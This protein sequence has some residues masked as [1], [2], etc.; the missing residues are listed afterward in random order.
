MLPDAETHVFTCTGATQVMD[1]VVHDYNMDQHGDITLDKAFRVSCNNAFAQAALMMGDTA[2]RRTAEAFG[3]NDNFLFRD[4]VVENS[5][6]PTQ[7]RNS[8]EIAWSG[9]GQSQVVATPMHMCMVA[10]AIANDGVMMEPRLLSLVESPTGKVRLR[11]SQK[12][13]RT[14]C[15]PE[16]AQIIDGYMKDVVKSGTGT[17]AQVSGLTIAGKTGSAEG[18]DNGM[19]VTYPYAIS[20]LVENG[21]SGGSVAAPVA[22]QV[23]EYLRDNLPS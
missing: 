16:M 9:A 13:Y 19:D 5:V 17:R 18:S 12:V 6:Y 8:V 21:G 20:V 15:S 22:R 7:N 4:L 11:Y 1:H 2:L 23:F 10:A 3:F 14:A